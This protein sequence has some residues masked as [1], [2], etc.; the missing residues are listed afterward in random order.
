MSRRVSS[1]RPNQ[2]IQKQSLLR[3]LSEFEIS[4]VEKLNMLAQAEKIK[5]IKNQLIEANNVRLSLLLSYKNKLESLKLAGTGR[6]TK[7]ITRLSMMIANLEAQE[8]IIHTKID[9]LSLNLDERR[10]IIEE[11][12]N[13]NLGKAALLLPPAPKGKG[14]KKKKTRKRKKPKKR[15]RKTKK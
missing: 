3:G 6:D 11:V 5:S 14:G 7:E 9:K 4:H 10:T 1:S 8:S 2:G 13:S 15:K 12:K